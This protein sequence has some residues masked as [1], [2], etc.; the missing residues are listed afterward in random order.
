MSKTDII[1]PTWNSSE[2]IDRCLEAALRQPNCRVLVVDNA[3]ED[4]TVDRVGGVA[5]VELI[6]LEENT[7]FAAACNRGFEATE[8]PFVLFLNDDAFVGD[9]YVSGLVALLEAKPDAASVVG[10]LFTIRD[11]RRF[12]DSAGIVLDRLRFRPLDRGHGELDRDQYDSREYVFG[13]SAAA[14][15]YR[16]SALVG[17]GESPFDEV[18][19]SYYEDVDLAW[20]LGRVGWHHI[21]EPNVS[22]EHA[23]RGPGQKNDEIAS[24]AF[25]NR[26]LIWLKNEGWRE[27]TRYAP[28]AIPWEVARVI[29]RSAMD[30]RVLAEWRDLPRR[31]Q[32][33][34]KKRMRKKLRKMVFK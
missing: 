12:I 34:A 11:G 9:D 25:L 17:L 6:A 8:S 32:L 33:V 10:K 13:G 15:V 1:I 18:L 21:Y 7:G 4:D 27:F 24:R 20:R 29:R 3:S 5:N 2:V 14:T 19:G 23:R 16:R 31:A 30:S 28:V 26:Y 22:A